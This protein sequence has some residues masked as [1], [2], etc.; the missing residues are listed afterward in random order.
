MKAFDVLLDA[1]KQIS[2]NFPLLLKYRSMFDQ[3]DHM[4]KVL[5]WIYEDMLKFH[6]RALRIFSQPGWLPVYFLIRARLS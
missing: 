6:L 1:Y 3:N 5:V 4:K 2:E